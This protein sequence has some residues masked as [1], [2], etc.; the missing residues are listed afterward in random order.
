MPQRGEVVALTD[1]LEA[2]ITDADPRRIKRLR[3]RP[4]VAIPDPPTG[5]PPAGPPPAPAD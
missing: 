3:L 5:P 4:L 1:D 2:E